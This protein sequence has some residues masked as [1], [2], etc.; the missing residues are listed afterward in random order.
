MNLAAGYA[1]S[2]G[3]FVAEVSPQ[4]AAG[5]DGYTGC[6]DSLVGKALP[7]QASTVTINAGL[8]P[9]SDPPMS[10]AGIGLPASLPT[11]E[12]CVTVSAVPKV[13]KKPACAS[14]FDFFMCLGASSTAAGSDT[15]TAPS[16]DQRSPGKNSADEGEATVSI[17]AVAIATPEAVQERLAEAVMRGDAAELQAALAEAQHVGLQCQGV[18]RARDVL[19]ALESS[20]VRRRVDLVVEQAVESDD[21]WRLQ[22][23]MQTVVGSG[24]GES[25]KVI[26][27][28]EAMQIHKRR[29]EV[30]SEM[31]RAAAARDEQRL[32]TAIEVALLAHIGEPD[33]RCA[34]DALRMLQNR[35][36]A[37][38]MLFKVLDGGDGLEPLEDALAA[39][40][41][42]NLGEPAPM[43]GED[44]E[45]NTALAAVRREL[46]ARALGRLEGLK[47]ADDTEALTA[48]LEEGTH[49]PWGL[50]DTEV[51]TFK[52]A[53][54][55]LRTW[56]SMCEELRE[57]I[58][59]G[60]K[61][62]LAKAVRMAEDA[63]IFLEADS[64][65]EACEGSKIRNALRL[66]REA[67][68]A[69]Q[70]IKEQEQRMGV[71]AAA[72]ERLREAV[73]G[74]DAVRLAQTLEAA[75]VAGFG[76]TAEI[77]HARERLRLLRARAG[78]AH[79]LSEAV[80]IGDV[81]R[82]RAALAGSRGMELSAA[83]VAA[84][85]DTLKSLEAQARTQH[86]LRTAVASRSPELLQS[87]VAEAQRT[88]LGK[89]EGA[90]AE[91]ELHAIGRQRVLH[92]L[93]AAHSSDDIEQLR[94][95][96][97]AA[98]DVGAT[99]SELEASLEHLRVL[100][101]SQWLRRELQA[102]VASGDTVKIIAAIKQAELAGV[103]AAPTKELDAAR[104]LLGACRAKENARQEL[105]LARAS[106]RPSAAVK[107]MASAKEAGLHEEE[108]TDLIA[109]ADMAEGSQELPRLLGISSVLSTQIP[110]VS[111][112]TS[113]SSLQSQGKQK[114]DFCSVQ[115]LAVNTAFSSPLSS[116][117]KK[118]QR[119]VRF[120]EAE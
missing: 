99:D 25:E 88:G 69:L 5:A 65:S 33:V 98:T 24:F 51:A 83:D 86:G 66:L 77:C 63:N 90:R 60:G 70:S 76:V 85:R 10:I 50:N 31:R 14:S 49:R 105:R 68:T 73:L 35:R 29:Q 89:R 36:A 4:Q 110:Q 57:A 74:D 9:S 95:A 1:A 43:L 118:S 101:S 26:V 62:N 47:A 109:I 45:E 106:G 27:L 91:A 7:H 97:R 112:S 96:L 67:R 11:Q 44:R 108:F 92:E 8:A 54:E 56:E 72:A 111:A 94:A 119:R 42:A 59:S 55:Q 58:R 75:E 107:A 12:V 19:L 115:A 15:L 81:Y 114:P 93:Q 6:T 80:R 20:D 116:V 71:K 37:K 82:L 84:A 30:L 100:E 13:C 61:E 23:A 87:A 53:I 113:P 48:A 120:A 28:K 21:W 41:R 79:E 22:A 32:R 104:S 38:Q 17:G 40:Q 3:S 2:I 34:R 16:T 102:A 52:A 78:A 18:R 117:A 103:S 46:H 39:A 64:S